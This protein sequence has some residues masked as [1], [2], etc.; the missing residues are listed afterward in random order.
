[1]YSR[2]TFG[3]SAQAT[4]SS[5]PIP[6]MPDLTSPHRTHRSGPPLLRKCRRANRQLNKQIPESE[7]PCIP[8]LGVSSVWSRAGGSREAPGPA[9]DC[10]CFLS[11]GS[12]DH[13]LHRNATFVLWSPGSTEALRLAAS[14]SGCDLEVAFSVK[15]V[16]VVGSWT[17]TAVAH[18]A[19]IGAG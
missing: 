14:V 2:S 4:P 15:Q 13:M 10:R 19:W 8:I 6:K 1:M 18:V 9:V 11:G 16:P 7:Q 3:P 5:P 12:G 17:T